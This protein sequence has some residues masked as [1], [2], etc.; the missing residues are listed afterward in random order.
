MR[1]ILI[2]ISF[3][4][5]GFF[6]FPEI[7][8]ALAFSLT[9]TIGVQIFLKSNESFMFREWAL[10][11]YATNYLL[12]PIIT[13]NL[14]S[15]Q[16]LYG[17][18]I[19]S[20]VYFSLAIPGFILFMAG[21]FTIPSRLFKPSFE[22]VRE[23]TELNEKFLLQTTLL[24]V[25]LR[26]SSDF[27][28]GESAFF[29]YLLSM[30]RFVGAFS[31]FACNMKK[32][33]WLA[34]LILSLEILFG[35]IAGMY[36]DAIMWLI[37]FSLF[38][39]YIRK[40]TITTKL[41]GAGV[42]VIFVLFIQA[43]KATYREEVWKEGKE[44]SIEII[45]DVGS[46]KTNSESL[47]GEDNLLSTLNRGNQAWI[48]ASTVDHMSLYKNY[49]GLTIVSKYLESALLPRF[50]APNKIESGDKEIFNQFSGHMLNEGTSMGLGIFADG[51]IA[52]GTWGVYIFG[53]VL[54]L[55]FSLT[56]KLV[57]RWT[58]VSPFYVLLL[59]PLLNYAV[60]PDCELQT[61][62]NHLFKG[63]LLYGFLVYLTRKRFTLDSQEN[64]RKLAHLN[65][66]T[67]K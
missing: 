30:V 37:F 22:R 18:K 47:I 55:I 41:I 43:I 60:R 38:Y 59:L 33:W 51:Y 32:Y 2:F 31:L 44:G 63:I 61:T 4:I 65:L 28:P 9:L 66:V 6:I 27:F 21:M 67:R 45:T 29:V 57:E 24:G 5:L 40:P 52:Y 12:S 13:Y 11:L 35:F 46:T 1:V 26:L 23:S 3:V 25:I 14:N 39:L 16:I 50:L 58:K 7:Y 10:F 56:F 34:F 15:D 19:P 42:L 17:M 20:D 53:F 64:Q 48:F 36:H 8:A 54:G 62:I 49:Q